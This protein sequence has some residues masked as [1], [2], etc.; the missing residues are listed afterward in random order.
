M[1]IIRSFVYIY[2]YI[3]CFLFII[4]NPTPS[5]SPI[6]WTPVTEKTKKYINIDSLLTMEDGLPFP[7]RM[8]LW[9]SLYPV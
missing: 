1:K 5:G 2:I 7:E 6:E 8:K 9:E 3:L 4:S